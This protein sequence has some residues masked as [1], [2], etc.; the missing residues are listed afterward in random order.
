MKKTI[1]LLFAAVCTLSLSS[2]ARNTQPRE[3]EKIIK[4]DTY[5][6]GL[7]VSDDVTVV[8][9]NEISDQIRITGEEDEV[10]EAYAFTEDSRLY[11]G[12]KSGWRKSSVTIYVPAQLLSQLEVAGTGLVKS[13]SVLSNNRLDVLISGACKVDIRSKGKINISNSSEY[14]FMYVK[15]GN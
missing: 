7:T 11:V 10:A 8:L 5:F 9:T 6:T 1:L 13:A 4:T 3:V 15:K 12:G 2:F 14:D